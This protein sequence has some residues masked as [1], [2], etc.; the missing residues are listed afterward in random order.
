PVYALPAA[1]EEF[2]GAVA[3]TVEEYDLS[4]TA[5]RSIC[6]ACKLFD[7]DRMCWTNF[8]GVPTAAPCVPA[9]FG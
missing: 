6:A 9:P 8:E 2:M 1:Q 5:Y 4:F 3:R 7:F